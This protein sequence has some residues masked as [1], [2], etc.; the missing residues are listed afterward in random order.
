MKLV[1]ESLNEFHQTSDPLKSLGIGPYEAYVNAFFDQFPVYRHEYKVE[2]GKTIFKSTLFLLGYDIDFIK[3]PDKLIING[4]LN[5]RKCTSLQSLPND[6]NIRGSLWLNGCTSLTELPD[7]LIVNGKIYVESSTGKQ[8]IDY[9][10][11]SIFAEK[12]IIYENH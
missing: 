1:R 5:L 7:D 8:L 10:E 2:D 4:D 9:I 11:Q 3:L 6:L 12:L